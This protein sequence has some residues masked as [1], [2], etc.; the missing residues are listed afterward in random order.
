MMRVQPRPVA[1]QVPVRAGCPMLPAFAFSPGTMAAPHPCT[2]YA[3]PIGVASPTLAAPTVVTAAALPACTPAAASGSAPMQYSAFSAAPVPQ[4]RSAAEMLPLA[5]ARV[6]R[7]AA[8]PDQRNQA[9]RSLLALLEAHGVFRDLP[10]DGSGLLRVGSPF[11]HD[12]FEAPQLLPFLMERLATAAPGASGLAVFGCDS[13]PQ[14]QWWSAWEAWTRHTYADGRVML[15]L[16]QRDLEKEQLPQCGLILGLHPEVTNGGPWPAII[17]NVL[18]SRVVGGRAIFATFYRLEA[19]ETVK[20]C[21]SF[22]AACEILE[23]PYYAGQPYNAVGTFLRFAVVVTLAVPA[24]ARM[25]A[26][27]FATQQAVI[28]PAAPLSV[29]AAVPTAGKAASPGVAVTGPLLGRSV[30]AISMAAPPAAVA[31][32]GG[33]AAMSVALATAITWVKQREAA[34]DQRDQAYLSFLRALS[35]EWRVLEGLPTDASGTLHVSTPFC[36]QFFE[37]PLLLPFLKEHVLDTGRAKGIA[38][39]GSDVKPEPFWWPAWE[40][41]VPCMLGPH[42]V[43]H[44]KAQDLARE[45]PAAAGLVLAVHPEVTTGGPWPVII[46]NVLRSCVPGG[47]CVFATFY[48]QEAEEVARICR[49]VGV[50]CSVRESPFYAGRPATEVGTFL[51]FA[52]I[53]GGPSA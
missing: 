29:V 48:A 17:G 11:C 7:E 50:P 35:T 18:R 1:A 38:T 14:A 22:G 27:A 26:S 2:V 34:P 32:T 12:F 19:E 3:P 25:P 52:V 46:A 10:V 6:G 15:E 13:R 45:L 33:Q 24:V 39:F 49:S 41:W 47:R 51:R 16:Q 28:V 44:L 5:L 30:P 43:L 36:Q 37:A 42:V 9:H 4:Q 40:E 31:S 23:N 53:A 21:S 8:V 20:V